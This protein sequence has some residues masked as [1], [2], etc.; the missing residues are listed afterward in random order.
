MLHWHISN[1]RRGAGTSPPAQGPE[2]DVPRLSWIPDG[3][4]GAPLSHSGP[5]APPRG[6]PRGPPRALE[7]RQSRGPR[8]PPRALAPRPH[9]S[10]GLPPGF[11]PRPQ[12][13]G[14]RHA[15]CNDDVVFNVHA[16]NFCNHA[17]IY[18]QCLYGRPFAMVVS[19]FHPQTPEIT[20]MVMTRLVITM[21]LLFHCVSYFDQ[22]QNLSAGLSNP[23]CQPPELHRR[24]RRG[25]CLPRRCRP[26]EPRVPGART[27]GRAS[28]RM[29]W[30]LKP[31]SNMGSK[32]MRIS[33]RNEP[34]RLG[35]RAG[36]IV[37]KA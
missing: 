14:H 9:S 17:N 30:G 32:Q 27:F 21:R 28:T 15:V 2:V 6:P 19:D 12:P 5:P 37:V 11:A 7:P 36:S 23:G 4:G 29:S 35:V 26:L 16:H 33:V 20:N 18:H 8:A 25:F 3:Q 24:R 22:T 13:D 1:P 34:G 31:L 10:S